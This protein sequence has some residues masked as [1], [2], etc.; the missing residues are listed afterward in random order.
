MVN[1]GAKLTINDIAKK[2]KTSKTTVSFYL[3][4]KF[5]K[6]SPDTKRRIE[7]VIEET[8]YS[9]NIMARSLKLKKSNLIGVVVADI[10]NPFSSNIV[11]GIGEITRRKGYQILVGSTNLDYYN[12]EEYFKK[13]LDMGVDGFIVQPT[14]NFDKLYPTIKNKG[15]KIVVLDSVSSRYTGKWVK[16]NN[17]EIV[18]EA[19]LKLAEKGYE[20]FI[21]VTE[22]PDKLAARMER[23]TGFEDA[24]NK[25]NCKSF[26]EIINENT[27]VDEIAEML[28][29][30][31][32]NNKKTVIFAI[33]GKIL[34]KVFKA[35]KMEGFDVPNH[36][37]IIGFD[38]WD[39]TMYASP[40]VT[41][42]DQPTYEE[43]KYAAKMLI[44]M[45]EENDDFYKSEVFDCN[46]NWE[47]ST[48][49]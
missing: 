15:K 23:K 46:I 28:K 30:N 26:I 6:M 31:I 24:V 1:E 38:K 33:N 4:G 19:V 10:T 37:G 12:E 7:Q 42:I 20:E 17:Y 29:I 3:N 32:S 18:Y 34:Q 2:A 47:E 48:D 11:K 27:E 22:A 8:N 40:S 16:T 25:I 39:W 49:L 43:G 13:M 9:P 14:K 44:E 36:V 45:I 21:L 41:T 35:V 5:D